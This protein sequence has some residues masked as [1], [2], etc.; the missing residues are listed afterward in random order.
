MEMKGQYVNYAIDEGAKVAVIPFEMHN[1]FMIVDLKLEG[2]LGLKFLVDT[3]S[4]NTLLIHREFADILGIKYLRQMYIMGVDK[5]QLISVLITEG[6]ELKLPGVTASKQNIL[7]LEEQMIE[8]GKYSGTK[9]DGI[10]GM[11]LFKRFLVKINYETNHL[12]VY[13]REI[14]PFKLEGYEAYD[15]LEEKGKMYL[16]EKVV[17]NS[18]KSVEMRWLI[19]TGAALTVVIQGAE[20]DSTILPVNV[21]PGNIGRGLGGFILGYKGR[22]KEI[23]LGEYQFA[24]MEGN[25]QQIEDSLATSVLTENHR[26]YGILGNQ[27]LRRFEV[28]VD[29]HKNKIYLKPNEYFSD[30][31]REDLSGIGLMAYGLGLN[32]FRVEDLD[33]LSPAYRAGVQAGDEILRVNGKQSFFSS[34]QGMMGTLSSK[35]GKNINLIVR[36]NGEKMKFRFKLERYWENE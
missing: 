21:R 28:L 24:D 6:V 9:I 4:D 5:K 3:G 29:Y 1:G 30:S 2:T 19:D 8:L 26:R 18:S 13:D 27:I 22:M 31:V 20:S 36:R 23:S 10:L 34:L 32:R 16:D 25:F 14:F 35:V 7:V 15:F 17:V 12:I 11:D 33:T